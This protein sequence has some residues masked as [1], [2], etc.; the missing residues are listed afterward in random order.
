MVEFL[1]GKKVGKN[2]S[3]LSVITQH[4]PPAHPPAPL[5]SCIIQLHNL[6][7]TASKNKSTTSTQYRS[8]PVT[9]CHG[10]W[11]MCPSF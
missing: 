11:N 2:C 5:L 9:N 8:P 7:W 1:R 3:N 4:Y 10:G 6:L